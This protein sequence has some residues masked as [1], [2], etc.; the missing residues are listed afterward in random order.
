VA[1]ALASGTLDGSAVWQALAV[2]TS[3]GAQ[4]LGWADQI[5]PRRSVK[6]GD[7]DFVVS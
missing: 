4:V 1:R 6:D 5:L 3:V 2:P 7:L